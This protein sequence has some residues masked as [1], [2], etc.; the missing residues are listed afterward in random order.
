MQTYIYRHTYI[1]IYIQ[2]YI[3]VYVYTLTY[4][5]TY[6]HKCIHCFLLIANHASLSVRGCSIMCFA[7]RPLP[8]PHLCGHKG[9]LARF[10]TLRS[11][12]SEHSVFHTLANTEVDLQDPQRDE[13]I[14]ISAVML[15]AIWPHS[16]QETTA[17]QDQTRT[18]VARKPITVKC[19]PRQQSQ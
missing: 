3:Y 13:V 15:L 1:S 5:H 14:S 8:I 18:K 6:I 2:S 16:S 10:A 19:T 11:D 4:L 9:G 12:F 17:I 7:T